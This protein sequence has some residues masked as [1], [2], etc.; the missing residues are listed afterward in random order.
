MA[1]SLVLKNAGDLPSVIK[2]DGLCYEL[3]GLVEQAHNA[4]WSAVTDVFDEC[5]DCWGGQDGSTWLFLGSGSWYYGVGAGS[6]VV[7]YRT[8]GYSG[9]DVGLA[10]A[11]TWVPVSPFGASPPP[12]ASYDPLSDT[13]TVLSAGAEA[14]IGVYYRQ[15]DIS[16]APAYTKFPS[17]SSSSSSSPAP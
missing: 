9:T 1:Q 7:W 10:L 5:V 8:E 17:S 14:V 4:D 3:S 11:A 13:V 2:I 12:N 15:D 6:D 16:G